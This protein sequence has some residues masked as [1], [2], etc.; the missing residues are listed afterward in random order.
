MKSFNFNLQRFADEGAAPQ[1]SAAPQETQTNGDNAQA[2]EPPAPPNAPAT[3][4]GEKGTLLGNLGKETG[5]TTTGAPETYDFK[6]ILPQGVEFDQK[7]VGEYS[8]IAKEYGLSQEAANKLGAFGIQLQQQAYEAALNEVFETQKGW[9]EAAKT[10][11]GSEFTAITTEAAK[12]IEVL[13]KHI[14][15]LRQAL[16]ETGAGNRVEFIRAMSMV[17]KL[18]AEDDGAKLLGGSPSAEKKSIYD[19]TDFSKY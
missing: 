10:E 5:A 3:E 4:Q 6:D 19:K 1:A 15:N 14:P 8:S 12:G 18:V 2:T 7:L 16:N 11:L 17:G 13:E 9:G